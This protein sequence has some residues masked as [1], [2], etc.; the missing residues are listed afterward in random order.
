VSGY[1]RDILLNA[2]IQG[3]NLG[4]NNEGTSKS[5]N[6]AAIGTDVVN[7]KTAFLT[8]FQ[9]LLADLVSAHL[10]AP[11]G[12]GHWREWIFRARG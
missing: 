11:H 6:N 9:P 3:V 12:F 7:S 8:V 2:K 1:G 5:R 10:I 4:L